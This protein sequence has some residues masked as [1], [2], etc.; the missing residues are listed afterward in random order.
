M[1][2]YETGARSASAISWAFWLMLP[3]RKRW[4]ALL[5]LLCLPWP[6]GPRWESSGPHFTLLSLRAC[7][8]ADGLVEP[9]VC[10]FCCHR[11]DA[12]WPLG[13]SPPLSNSGNF[14]AAPRAVSPLASAYDLV[15]DDPLK[16]DARIEESSVEWGIAHPGHEDLIGNWETSEGRRIE[17]AIEFVRVAVT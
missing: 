4:M 2:L 13:D 8:R 6:E 16:G 12:D 15:L 7:Q 1:S 3:D 10:P 11:D 17:G 9:F 14:S 5:I